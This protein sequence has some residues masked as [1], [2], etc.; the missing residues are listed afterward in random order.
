MAMLLAAPERMLCNGWCDEWTRIRD[1]A[2]LECLYGA[3]LRIS[4]LCG[5][6]YSHINFSN[7]LVRVLGKGNKERIVPAGMTAVEAVNRLR[8]ATPNAAHG[9]QP[10]F[11]T[12][13]GNIKRL[14]PRAVQLLLKHCLDAAGLPTDLTPHKLRH[15]CA[16]HL[17]DH[18]ADL[19][20]IQEQLGHASL[21][22]TQI[23][24]HVSLA[25]LKSAHAA[26]HPRA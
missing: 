22:T 13:K 7:G 8:K 18:N 25:R 2:I 15:T 11:T 6:N 21:S 4:E 26:A 17:L 24:T 20:F 9:D 3:G 16:T 10:V 19:R 5:L 14:Y 1:E 12:K 23:Y